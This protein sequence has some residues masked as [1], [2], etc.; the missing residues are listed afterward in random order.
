MKKSLK[1]QELGLVLIEVFLL[2]MH[3]SVPLLLLNLFSSSTNESIV[4]VTP[5]PYH[6][7]DLPN[8]KL[9]G[10]EVNMAIIAI[11]KF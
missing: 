6:L 9:Q 4:K 10:S 8:I 7:M 2:C 3:I 1:N 5:Q 11:L